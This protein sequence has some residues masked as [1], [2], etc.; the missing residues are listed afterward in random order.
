MRDEVRKRVH[1]ELRNQKPDFAKEIAWVNHDGM[2]SEVAPV[3]D[4]DD[5]PPL[6]GSRQRFVEA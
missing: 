5:G 4:D 1:Q 6:R 3:P 2:R